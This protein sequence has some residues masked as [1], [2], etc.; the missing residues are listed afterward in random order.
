M[1]RS[2]KNSK[3]FTLMEVVIATAL[4][5]ILCAVSIMNLNVFSSSSKN[6]A[7]ELNSF[8]KRARAKAVATTQSY[9]IQPSSTSQITSKYAKNCSATTWTDDSSLSL[10]FPKG[11]TL[12]GTAW[13]LC[14]NSRGMSE[15]STSIVINNTTGS[16][17]VQVMLGGASRVL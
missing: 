11:A 14:F 17:T 12:S 16:K 5:G 10:K 6:S 4:F 15:S 1:R 2:R 13:S 8:L 9:M 7:N 3:G